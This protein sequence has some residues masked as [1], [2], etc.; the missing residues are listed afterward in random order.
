LD[1]DVVIQEAM[2]QPL[3]PIYHWGYLSCKTLNS[4]REYAW[5]LWSINQ[6]FNMR[7]S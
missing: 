5:V 4:L 1:L 6:L 2:Q 3:C 7:F